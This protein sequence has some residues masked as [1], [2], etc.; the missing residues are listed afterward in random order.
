MII[1]GAPEAKDKI[2]G[3]ETLSG[4]TRVVLGSRDKEGFRPRDQIQ[5]LGNPCGRDPS[6]ETRLLICRQRR[7][8]AGGVIFYRKGNNLWIIGMKPL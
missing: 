8:R 5:A 7:K 4:E 6:C 1:P 2:H 3:P